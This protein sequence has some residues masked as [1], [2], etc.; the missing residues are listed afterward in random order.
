MSFICK[1]LGHKRETCYYES[2]GLLCQISSARLD[3]IGR[4]H[5]YISTKCER[6]KE[7]VPLGKCI[8]KLMSSKEEGK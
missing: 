4:A 7:Q 5:R 1:V 2:D 6:C 3:G 8:D